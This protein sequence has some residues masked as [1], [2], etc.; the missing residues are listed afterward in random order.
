[1]VVGA[2]KAAAA[3]AAALEAAWGD[4][5]LAGVVVTQDGYEQPC[6]RIDVMAASHPI[7]DARSVA[8]ARHML[9][10][11]Q[12][13]T[14]DDLVIALISGG[15][16]SLMALPAAGLT[17]ADKQGVSAAL[18][19]SGAPIGDINIVRKHLSAIKGG[20]LAAAARPA[21]VVTLLIS[22]VPGDDARLIASG[23]TAPDPSTRAEAR[24]ILARYAVPLSP[25]V[26]EALDRP[27]D[28]PH[29]LPIDARMIA[30]PATALAAAADAARAAGLTPLLLGDALEG[31]AREV[32]RVLAGMA[33]SVQRNAAPVAP[34][35]VLLCGGETTVTLAKGMTGHG[36]RNSEFLLSFALAMNGAPG[37][38]ALAADTDG[39]DGASD[40]AGAMVAPDSLARWRTAGLDPRTG[41][42]AHNSAPLFDALGDLVR[43]G[44]TY[45]NVNDFRAILIA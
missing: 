8:A 28:A 43:T 23:P 4:V 21:R 12:D 27:D 11:V 29:L 37:V 15:G 9:G 39:L 16:S 36:G 13:L 17:L 33:A 44:P 45:T 30:T 40:A 42:R 10:R 6:G 14:A 26:R 1:M 7:P 35:A 31:E 32:G 24:A 41:L 34:P 3:M 38:W 22:D 20:R 2:G 5:D 25:A 18:L 19:A